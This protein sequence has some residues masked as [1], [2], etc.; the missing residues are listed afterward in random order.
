MYAFST[1]ISAIFPRNSSVP[2]SVLRLYRGDEPIG[3]VDLD[4]KRCASEGAGWISL[5]YLKEEYRNKGYGIQVL[6]RPIFF[7]K[8]L[9][10]TVLRLQVAE[11]NELARAFYRREGFRVIGEEQ[12]YDGRLFVMERPLEKNK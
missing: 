8:A 12:G 9:G 5:L 2:G 6:A 1:Q 4:P 7:Y 10:R 3:L 11:T